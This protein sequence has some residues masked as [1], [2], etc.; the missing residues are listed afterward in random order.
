MAKENKTIGRVP[1]SRHEY[2]DGATYYKDNIVTR[3]GS[4]FQCTVESTTTPPATLDGDGNIVLGDG[5]M[6]FADASESRKVGD[7]VAVLERDLGQYADLPSVEMTAETEGKYINSDG[8]FV[9]DAAWSVAAIGAVVTGNS[10]LLKM[11]SAD[12]MVKGVALFVA[13]I[14]ETLSSGSKRTTYTPLFSA[15]NT[16]IPK[17][18]YVCLEAMQSYDDVLVCYRNDVEGASALLVRRYGS[19]ASTAT[20]IENL[21]RQVDLKSFADGYYAG[22]RVGTADNLT[23]RGEA[24]EEVIA[25]RKTGGSNEI[26]EGNATIRTIKGNSFVMNQLWDTDGKMGEFS[27]NQTDKYTIEVNGTSIRVTSKFTGAANSPLVVGTYRWRHLCNGHKY[28]NAVSI[29]ENTFDANV[30]YFQNSETWQAAIGLQQGRH[31]GFKIFSSNHTSDNVAVYFAPVANSAIKEG[32][33]FLVDYANIIDL[34]LMFGSG[35]EPATVG[36]FAQRLGYDSIED[37][38]YIPYNPGEI[39]DMTA[40]GI[41]TTGTEEDGSKWTSERSWKTTLDKYFGGH[42]RSAGTAHDEITATKAVKRVDVVKMKD[43][44]W[45]KYTI[46]QNGIILFFS[47]IPAGKYQG[48]TNLRCSRYA[49]FPGIN[50]GNDKYITI[51]T[52]MGPPYTFIIVDS[53]FSSVKEFEASL[54]DDDVVEYELATPEEYDLDELNLTERVEPGGTEE[55]VVPEGEGIT[56]APLVADIVYPIDSYNTIKANK[57]RIGK[58]SSLATTEKGSLVAAVNELVNKNASAESLSSQKD[59]TTAQAIVELEERIKSLESSRGLLGDATAGTI[60]VKEVTKCLYPLVMRAHGVPAEANVPENLPEGLPWDGI[61]AFVGQLYIN[62][63]AASGGLYYA[64]G[65]DSVNDWKQA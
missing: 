36:E 35:N 13:R 1:V 7:R 12:K 55:I 65:H 5:W 33:T 48:L 3:Y 59:K 19:K 6:F 38:P 46:P 15:T 29:A 41:R 23:A 60:D 61:P 39:V 57:E 30:W 63:D 32:Q 37:V 17:S 64:A 11:G 21:R 27:F 40:T 42:L 24:S 22:M 45:L 50:S 47:K 49:V 44:V 62:L 14:V 53:A 52:Y 56:S 25:S 9:S 58:V 34:T 16:E 10:Y 8:E 20:Q 43:L 26:E 54:T 2:A 28:L 51:P 18:G 31:K 4:A